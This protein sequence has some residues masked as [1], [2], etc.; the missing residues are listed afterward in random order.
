HLLPAGK[1]DGP[2]WRAGS[3]DGEPGKSL[4]VHLT[5]QKAGVW[6]DFA[7]GESGDL[8]DLWMA[9]KRIDFVAAMDEARDFLGIERPQFQTQKREWKRPEKPKCRMPQ[10]R[11]R[12]YLLEDR[13]LSMNVLQTYKIGEDE[14]GNIIFP[15]RLPDGTLAMAKRREAIDG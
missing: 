1:K 10:E 4:G 3:R 11:A 6:S 8:L 15:F 5:G 12:D 9:V 7:T 2:E 14:R 13:N